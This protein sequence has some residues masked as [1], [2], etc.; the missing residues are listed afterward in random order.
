MGAN[1]SG[2]KDRLRMGWEEMR[3]DDRMC[4]DRG[5]DVHRQGERIGSDFLI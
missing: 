5:Y 1:W 4:I 3:G 2:V